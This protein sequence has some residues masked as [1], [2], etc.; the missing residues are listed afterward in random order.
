MANL[1]KRTSEWTVGPRELG[2]AQD[3]SRWGLH[4]L[5]PAVPSK[6]SLKLEITRV[7]ALGMVLLR[8]SITDSSDGA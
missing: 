6:V 3:G 4:S 7:E 8:L 1:E 2:M 5:E